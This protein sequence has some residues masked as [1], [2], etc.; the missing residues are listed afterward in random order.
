MARMK[1]LLL[2]SLL[3]VL[4]VPATAHSAV[5]CRNTIFNDWYADGKI[6]STYSHGCYVDAL[7]HIPADASVY[8]SLSDDIKSAMAGAVH[9]TE[10]KPV[11]KQ[12]GHGFRSLNAGVKGASVAVTKPGTH[13]PSTGE[14]DPS[15][16]ERV[17]GGGGI[18]DT[19]SSAPLPILILGGLAIALAA[20]GAIGSGVK[21]AQRRRRP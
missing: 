21:F 7:R 10:G 15:T 1:R 4:A 13:D 20:A 5:P 19:A 17:A 11:P 14:R 9:R 8:S 18:A 16:G 6:A 3:V 12:I 2:L